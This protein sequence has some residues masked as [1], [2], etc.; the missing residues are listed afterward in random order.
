MHFLVVWAVKIKKCHRE[1]G[2][3]EYQC[4]HEM[5]INIDVQFKHTSSDFNQSFSMDGV[6]NVAFG[7]APQSPLL[8]L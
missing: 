8:S 3:F 1:V 2:Q 5:K 6:S 4:L 7:I